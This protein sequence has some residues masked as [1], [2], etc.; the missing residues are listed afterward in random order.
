MYHNSFEGRKM[1][2]EKEKKTMDF[3]SALEEVASDGKGNGL[4][5]E[6]SEHEASIN[7][8]FDPKLIDVVTQG[9]TI[10]LMLTRLKEDEL[11]L[12]PDFQRRSNLW[13][14][15]AKS[16]LIESLLLRIPIPSFYVAEDRDGDY[17][18]VDG[19][20]RM[21]AISHF[22]DVDSLNKSV[23][24]TLSPLHLEGLDSLS[25]YNGKSYA[26]LP[27][28][29]QRRIN[30]TELT[31]HI[32][33]A[34]TPPAVKFNI[35]SRINRGGMP[36]SAQEIRN[37]VYPGEWRKRVN[38]LAGSAYFK[39]ATSGKIRGERM[40]DNELILRFMALYSLPSDKLRPDDQTLDTFLNDFV[41]KVC[42][43]WNASQWE[44]IEKAFQKAMY[45]APLVFGNIA[46]R[47]YS[48]AWDK[49]RKPIN[50]SLFESEAVAL[51]RFSQEE[52]VKIAS[53]SSNVINQ[54]AEIFREDKSFQGSLLYATG[55]G[56]SS[57]KRL[58]I[59][60]TILRKELRA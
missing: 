22:V 5:P 16:S 41:E 32:I 38:V 2:S 9:R 40:E 27:R 14:L 36:L 39:E 4:E 37:A 35:F 13:D 50:R 59:I 23:G 7:I 19:L 33:R 10:A 47:K 44:D 55:K 53:R 43:S 20:Q 54:F 58:N 21:C 1:V 15:E 18:M 3:D 28:P 30:E 24:T 48:G 29:F 42:S 57:N 51:A 6:P 26:E 45:W 12:S 49:G 31:L 60:D 46:F 11:D 8:P 25:E 17:S 34:S 56:S 52:L